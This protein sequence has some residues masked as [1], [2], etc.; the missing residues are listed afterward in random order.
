MTTG[1]VILNYNNATDTIN[2]VESVIKYNTAKIKIVIVDNGSPNHQAID[3]ISKYVSDK[4]VDSSLIVQEGELCESK[5]LPF[6]TYLI[7]KDNPGY[8]EGNNKGLRLLYE[9][10]EVDKVMILNNDILFIEDFIPRLADFLD[11]K[12]DAGIVCPLL[13][14][15]DQTSIDYNCARTNVN[16]QELTRVFW[17][18]ALG[19][20]Y[21]NDRKHK[22][23]LNNPHAIENECL[24]IELPSGSCMLTNK[25]YFKSIGGFDPNTF[26]Y[27]EENIL[28]EKIRKT[29]R[30]NYICP[31]L[32]CVHLGASTTN[33]QVKSYPFLA[34]SYESVRYYVNN[35]TNASWYAKKL[36]LLSLNT[37]LFRKYL[38]WVFKFNRNK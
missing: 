18:Y 4:F 20:I 25:D 17:S 10:A 12:P 15:K 34:K 37:F 6:V 8:A 32:K 14:K 30:K 28:F 22:I 5:N 19:L 13:L 1:I 31:K 38:A 11:K 21:N 35:Y 33:K 26:L 9:D 27:Y 7:S 29:G 2:C 16:V 23:L 24:E 3:D 36:F